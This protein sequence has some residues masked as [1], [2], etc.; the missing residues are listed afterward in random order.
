LAALN[1]FDPIEFDRAYVQ[2][3]GLYGFLRLAW[4]RI[5]PGTPFLDN[6]HLEEVCN[7]LE[8]VSEGVIKRL[9]INIPPGTGKSILTNVCWPAFTWI[10]QPGKKWIFASYAP[11]L[12]ARDARRSRELIDSE[13]FQAR[14][15]TVKLRDRAD[16]KY[17]TSANGWRFSTSVRGEV[18]GRH[19]DIQVCDDPIKPILTQ[20]KAA[21][22]RNE[23]DFVNTWWDSTMA[24]RMANPKT[25]ARVI[26]MQRLHEDDLSGHAL[27]SGDYVHL[28]FPMRFEPDDACITPWGGDPRTEDKALLHPDRFGETEAAMLEKDLGVYAEGQLQQRPG[29][30]GGQ[31]FR[32]DWFKFWDHDTLAELGCRADGHGFDMLLCSW[33]MTFKDTLGSDYVC[34]QVWGRKAGQFFLLDRVY[35]RLNFPNTLASFQAMCRRWPRLGPKLVEDK[36]NGPAVIATLDRKITGLIAREPLGS[37]ITR[38]NAV[39][40][41]HK[42]GNVFYPSPEIAPWVKATSTEGGHVANMLGFPLARHDDTVDA[43]TQAL[44]YF[45][46][47]DNALFEVLAQLAK[48]GKIVR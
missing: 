45:V 41:L 21:V 22:T 25:A 31:I 16:T 18:T 33:D 23:I 2:A 36:A 19:A 44:A 46:E 35:E 10:N 15:P 20:G 26:I 4:A 17:R 28:R 6:W 42:A 7:H 24:S 48:Q 47:N 38:A 3:W 40:Y 39:S 29:K 32:G 5:E 13:W 27:E 37:K 11:D 14:W 30:V 1:Q 9:V 43:E 12:S 8:L 34:G